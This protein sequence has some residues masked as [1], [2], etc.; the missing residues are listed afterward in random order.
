[1]AI[2]RIPIGTFMDQLEKAVEREDGYIMGAKGQNPR[3]WPKTSWYFT[4][5]KDRDEYT[6]AQEKKALH[7]RDHAERVWDCNGLPEG[8]YEDFTQINI[9]TKARYNYSGWCG[10]KGTGMIP[11]KHRKRGVAVFWG[12]KAAS[13]THVAYLYKPVVANKP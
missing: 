3:K 9:N 12:S 13:I 8:I 10:T 4:Q 7:W 5:Y 11:V 1:M 6:A 2:K